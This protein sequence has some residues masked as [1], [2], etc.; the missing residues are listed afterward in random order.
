MRIFAS[1]SGNPSRQVAE[2][3]KEWLPNVIQ[4][5]E[6]YVSS[7]DIAK[8]ERWS[9]NIASNLSE[10]E[11][12]L[13]AITRSNLN[14]PWV[15]FEA[16]ALSKT[17]KGVVIPILCDLDRI[18]A[19]NSPLRQ[20]QHALVHQDEFFRIVRDI[21]SRTAR[22]LEEKRL[23]MVFLKWW[24]DFMSSFEKIQ[25]EASEKLSPKE[26][27]SKRLQAIEGAVESML[28]EMSRLRR[29]LSRSSRSG[30]ALSH[31]S[32][33]KDEI[34]RRRWFKQLES[35]PASQQIPKHLLDELVS[36]LLKR[37]QSEKDLNDGDEPN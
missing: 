18:E 13:L 17:V 1:W 31:L 8:G 16:G 6:V 29:E 30:N 5:V 35:D 37:S 28:Q 27:E 10:I 19:A 11:F 14:A 36:N 9:T 26:T 24:P 33:G 25:F 2:L 34:D 23:E 20:F 3:I 4:E 32:V 21:N 15:M 12:G 7:Q 22:P